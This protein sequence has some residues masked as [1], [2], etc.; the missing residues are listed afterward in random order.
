MGSL[1]L[2]CQAL[3]EIRCWGLHQGGPG[4]LS[5]P[6]VPLYDNPRA[7]QWYMPLLSGSPGSVPPCLI[8]FHPKALHG[9]SNP[10]GGTVNLGAEGQSAPQTYPVRGLLFLISK[11]CVPV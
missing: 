6:Q 2:R 5:W 8:S 11:N 7:P 1:V 9:C 4:Y 10:A 3:Y